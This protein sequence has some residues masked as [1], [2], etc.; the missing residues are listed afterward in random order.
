[1]ALADNG[2]WDPTVF[3]E[4]RTALVALFKSAYGDNADTDPNTADGLLISML[5]SQ[6]ALAYDVDTKLWSNGF[7]RSATGDALDRILD[8]LG[9]T[10]EPATESEVTAVYYGTPGT[11]VPASTTALTSDTAL[12]RFLTDGL[13]SV[14][15]A[16]NS[17]TWV[18][19]VQEPLVIP[20]LYVVTVGANPPV[21][22][23]TAPGDTVSTTSA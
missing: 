6:F 2:T 14:G 20:D 15:A 8:M 19:R 1:M 11:A 7:Y 5:A 18:I 3:A 4:I 13:V 23:L 12:N 22:Y 9:K 17:D 21:G 16:G 10:R